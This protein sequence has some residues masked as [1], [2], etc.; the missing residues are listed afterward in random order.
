MDYTSLGKTGLKVSVA[1]LG[2][3]GSSRLGKSQGRPKEDSIALIRRAFELGVNF[4]DTAEGYG[5][6]EIVGEAIGPLAR[7]EVV[8]S[9]KS[10]IRRDGDLISGDQVVESLE[11]SLRR[12]QLDHVDVFHLHGV[13]PSAYEHVRNEMVPALLRE[14]EKGK[15]RH[16]GVTETGPN[17]HRH[18][19]LEKALEEDCWEVVMF[20][21]HMLNQNARQSVFPKTLDRGVGTLLMFVVRRIFSDPAYLRDSIAKL[22]DKGLVPADIASADAPL[23]FLVHPGGAEDILDAAYRFARH[24]PGAEVV[25]FGTG[26][27]A[28]LERNIASILKPALPKADTDKLSEMF[29]TLEGVGLDLPVKAGG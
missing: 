9:T 17:D 3:G 18:L 23:G 7:D 5:T 14:K 2:C 4:F 8:I 19:M 24:E 16:L 13:P 27:V 21:F 1:G 12:L 10:G 15:L 25:L 11:A 28:H 22:A 26:S 29:G 20:A 6:E